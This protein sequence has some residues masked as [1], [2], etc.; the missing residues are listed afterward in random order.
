MR[1]GFNAM[2][3]DTQGNHLTATTASRLADQPERFAISRDSF[4]CR[5][6]PTNLVAVGR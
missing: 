3:N 4:E 6:A 5:N 2:S 1:G